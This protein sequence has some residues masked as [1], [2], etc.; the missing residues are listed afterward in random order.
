ARGA[1]LYM[2]AKRFGGP[3]MTGYE[4]HLEIESPH[5][6]SILNVPRNFQYL[7]LWLIC[8]PLIVPALLYLRSFSNRYLAAGILLA[9]VSEIVLF[10]IF[11]GT[12]PFPIRYHQ[13]LVVLLSI[14]LLL[15]AESLWNRWQERGLLYCGLLLILWNLAVLFQSDTTSH[16]LIF[17]QTGDTVTAGPP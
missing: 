1:L 4:T 12:H 17:S 7:I 6:M 5:P 14:P 10:Q 13:S 2:N 16:I 9:V 11:T 8:V 3:F 15:V